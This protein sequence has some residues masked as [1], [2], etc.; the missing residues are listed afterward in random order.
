MKKIVR[1]KTSHSVYGGNVYENELVKCLKK[2]YEV[3]EFV[4]VSKA[5]SRLKYI[6]VFS[7]FYKLFR[8]SRYKQ[9]DYTIRALETSFFLPSSA[10]NIVVAH[11]YD[12]SYSNIF[13]KIMQYMAFRSLLFQKKRVDTLIVVSAY[14][15][16]FFSHYGFKKIKI[17]YNSFNIEAYNRTKREIDDFK[18]KYNLLDK[19]IIYIGNPQRKKGCDEVYEILKDEEYYLI[20]SGTKEFD[21]GTIHLNL[22]H[23]SYITLLASSDLVVLN[24]KFKEGWNRV[25]HEA[26]LCKTPV[27]GSGRG[28][29]GELLE[30]AKQEKLTTPQ[31]LKNKIQK[32]F[33]NYSIYVSNGYQWAIQYD[34]D[35]FCREINEVVK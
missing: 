1:V 10:K 35:Y 29:M 17:I 21:L 3:E 33:S 6:F 16:A 13:S 25:A 23:Y 32:V 26:L 22:D 12:I 30:K 24:S 2:Q 31:E 28:G 19:K 14:W 5:R 18:K 27:I 20:T 9:Y 4:P 15:K 8:I 34:L 11:H 7:F